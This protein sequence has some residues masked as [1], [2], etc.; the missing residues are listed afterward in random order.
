MGYRQDFSLA[1]YERAIGTDLR[2]VRY[3]KV[4]D[5]IG[6][7]S[8]YVEQPNEIVPAIERSLESGKPSLVNCVIRS[9]AS[10]LA[11]AMIERKTT[12]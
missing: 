5:A 4:V 12:N 2:T 3:D 10:P 6:G 11:Q 9:G 1:Y 7:H 8:E